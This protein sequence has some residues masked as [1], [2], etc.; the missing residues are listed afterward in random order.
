MRM[1]FALWSDSR[2]RCLAREDLDALYGACTCYTFINR[3][4]GD[5]GVLQ[6]L[7]HCFISPTSLVSCFIAYQE[8]I[9]ISAVFRFQLGQK[10]RS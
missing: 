2:A 1:S 6:H 8:L 10:E 7:H 3:L 9:S 4:T 5:P